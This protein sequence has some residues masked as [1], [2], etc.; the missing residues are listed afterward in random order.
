[1]STITAGGKVIYLNGTSS[2]GKTTL[3][4]A[5]LDALQESYFNFSINLFEQFLSRKQIQR[6]VVPDIVRLDLGFIKCIEGLASSGN[7]LIVDDV[8][9]PPMDLSSGQENFTRDMLRRRVAVLSSIDVFFVKVYCPLDELERREVA[10]GDRTIGQ[11]RLQFDLVHQ[12]SIYDFAVD[13]SKDTPEASA[14]QVL[15]A[16]R[17]HANPSAF[18][19]M[20]ERLVQ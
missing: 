3:T 5:L 13:T 2:S 17:H 8:I 12:Y 14:A 18:A 20:R 4:E 19:Q 11:A 1:M 15:D 10:R 9:A 6:G 16:F 7:N